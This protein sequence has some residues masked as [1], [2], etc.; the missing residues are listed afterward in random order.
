MIIDSRK[1]PNLRG[2]LVDAV[3]SQPIRWARWADL[4]TGEFEAFKFDPVRIKA[5][6]GIPSDFLYRGQTQLRFI[7]DKTVP[8]RQ[9]SSLDARAAA[10]QMEEIRRTTQRKLLIPGDY[11]D[12]R[13]CG[14]LSAWLVA[15]ER[16]LEPLSGPD[17]RL[18]ERGVIVDTHAWCDR[19]Y[20]SP[21]STSL[22][23]VES[24]VKVLVARPQ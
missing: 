16:I 20:R 22:R 7:E 19:H 14:R 12:V 15:D 9:P 17:G 21:V 10:Q 18:Q 4:S 6:G 8:I 24:E 2:I 3:T 23:G 5:L 1:N 13:G 11:C